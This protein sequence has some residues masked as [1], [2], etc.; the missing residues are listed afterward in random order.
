MG[1]NRLEVR[2]FFLAQLKVAKDVSVGELW[3]KFGREFN[4]V[5]LR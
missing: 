4:P 5:L 3:G 2:V 1:G